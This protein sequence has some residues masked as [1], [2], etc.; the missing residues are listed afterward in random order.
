MSVVKMVASAAAAY[1]LE[2]G[3]VSKKSGRMYATEDGL[4]VLR[5]WE[6]PGG[7]WLQ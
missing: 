4:Q 6:G 5:R 3:Y 7:T 2:R 1:L